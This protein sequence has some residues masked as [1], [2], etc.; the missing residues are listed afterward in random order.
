[1]INIQKLE[2]QTET[3]FQ[4]LNEFGFFYIK[5]HGVSQENIKELKKISYQFFNESEE[6]KQQISMNKSGTAWRGYF[7]LGTELTSGY[8]DQKEGIYF[9][10]ENEQNGLPLH[11]KNLWPKDVRYKRFKNIV[12]QHMSEMKQLG[13]IIL[14]TIAVS[15]GLPNNYFSQRFS[16]DPTTLFRIFNYPKVESKGDWGVQE[17]TDMGFLTILMQDE[18]SGLEVKKIDGTW[19][20]APPIKDTLIIN[21]GDML[22]LWTGGIFRATPHRV[23]NTE[24]QNRLSFPYFY[25][26]NWETNLAPIPEKLLS[27]EV[28]KFR[29]SSFKRAWDGID[30][31]QLSQDLT[32]GEFVWDKVRKVFPHIKS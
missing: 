2:S 32:Y 16:N 3:L 22:E 8:P 6:F 5:N 13:E 12:T 19:F 10:Q 17:H 30:L 20:E 15:L 7:S 27:E 29:K 1:M 4:A 25:D 31:S 11:G 18:C 24:N 28:L 21:I 26:P 14:S 9:G 23:K